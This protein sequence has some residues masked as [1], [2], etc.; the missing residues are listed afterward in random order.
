M[1]KIITTLVLSAALAAQ[2]KPLTVADYWAGTDAERNAYVMGVID[3]ALEERAAACES[4][5][6]GRFEHDDYETQAAM[7]S[8]INKLLGD[9]ELPR[10]MYV[11][12][13]VR[14]LTTR[15]IRTCL[16]W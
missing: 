5:K 1:K 2:A 14:T 12:T 8:S 7:R 16:K 6:H 9:P 3:S 10:T 11:S 4:I 13:L 15:L